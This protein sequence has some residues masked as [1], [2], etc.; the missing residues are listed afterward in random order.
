M[1]HAVGNCDEPDLC[2]AG[3]AQFTNVSLGSGT[4]APIDS[5]GDG[6]ANCTDPDLDGDGVLNGADNCPAT[7]NAGQNDADSN[8]IGDMCEVAL[9]AVPWAG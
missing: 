4:T 3:F 6:V 2:A 8:G 5:D 1:D 7:P 9:A